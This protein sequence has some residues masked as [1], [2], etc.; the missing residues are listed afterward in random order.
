MN[1]II[2][3]LYI[4]A[5]ASMEPFKFCFLERQLEFFNFS[6]KIPLPKKY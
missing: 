4:S 2:H 3:K 6:Y 1:T 5:F